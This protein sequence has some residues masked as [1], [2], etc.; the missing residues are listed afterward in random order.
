[1]SISGMGFDNMLFYD[2]II[3]EFYE[4]NGDWI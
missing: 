1:M 4:K 2:T 3:C